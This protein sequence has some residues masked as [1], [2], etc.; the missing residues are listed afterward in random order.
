MQLALWM[1]VLS[2]MSPPESEDHKAPPLRLPAGKNRR[3]EPRYPY[4]LPIEV[5][6]FD[7]AG[8]FF[9][10]GTSTVDASFCGCKFHLRTPVEKGCVVAIR[11]LK[12][13]NQSE[14]DRAT[15]LFQVVHMA[16][17]SRGW[18]VGVWKLQSSNAWS[19][20]F[21]DVAK[22]SNVGS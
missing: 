2:P 17:E 18:T 3:R 6:G 9:T 5:S 22:P 15:L 7:H 8:R 14:R 10:E 19:A 20:E 16:Q 11:L 21:A 13:R 1:L 4:Q 12:A